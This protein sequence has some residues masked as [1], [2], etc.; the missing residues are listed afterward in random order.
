[1]YI[2]LT[3][4]LVMLHFQAGSSQR[5]I[6]P[7]NSDSS[8]PYTATIGETIQA[9]WQCDYSHIN[10]NVY[11]PPENGWYSY[12]SL[13][14]NQPNNNSYTFELGQ[15]LLGLSPDGDRGNNTTYSFKIEEVDASSGNTTGD[16]F[17][18]QDFF[19]Y[20]PATGATSSA[21]APP[22]TST[23]FSSSV[24]GITTVTATD[25]WKPTWS[26]S[27]VSTTM[28]TSQVSPQVSPQTSGTGTGQSAAAATASQTATG[29]FPISSG[30]SE[31]QK[32][33][34]GVGIG[35]GLPA[36][37]VTILSLYLRGK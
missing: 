16:G 4:S 35:I 8:D 2:L 13:F 28:T 11:G 18:T 15:N 5:F 29:A 31:D 7:P 12:L 14:R 27:T 9:V 17:S 20:L 33:A 26:M 24:I 37:L 3:L 1:M 19:I 25:T 34:L 22:T 30:Y 6:S 36:L 32:I 10:F 23:S 21:M